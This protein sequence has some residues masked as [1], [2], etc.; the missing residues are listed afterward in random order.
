M[1]QRI[2]V[3]EASPD[4]AELS[5]S[6]KYRALKQ[7]GLVVLCGAWVVLGLVGH[8]PWKTEDATTFGIVYEMMRGRRSRHAQ[9][10]RRA[11]HRPP[12]A[13]LRARGRDGQP[14][15]RRPRPARRRPPRR[16][17]PARPHAGRS[18]GHV[19]RAL[20]PR[21]P[22]DAACC[23]SWDRSDCGIAPTSSLP[24]SGSCSASRLA[25]TDSRSDCAAASSAA[26]CSDWASPSRSFREAS[27]ARCGSR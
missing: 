1:A 26:R 12:A 15:F 21:V 5:P 7:F 13:R 23:Y 4:S 8:D 27:W 2:L 22:L 11:V 3:A 24:S 18:G 6:G 16:R 14:V 25:S 20:R 17:T 10:H 19:P 9:S